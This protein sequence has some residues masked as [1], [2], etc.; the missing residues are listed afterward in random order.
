MK[1][2]I[3]NLINTETNRPRQIGYTTQLVFVA[4]NLHG[5]V[6]CHS[7]KEAKRLRSEYGV[8]AE[9]VQSDLRGSKGPFIWDTGALVAAHCE[10]ELLVR[11]KDAEIAALKQEIESFRAK[12]A[13]LEKCIDVM[14]EILD[15]RNI[16]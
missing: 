16:Y 8:K 1:N 14:A 3:D 15:I 10:V 2:A 9:S 4:K 12:E 13:G 5:T 7:E 11:K 6:L